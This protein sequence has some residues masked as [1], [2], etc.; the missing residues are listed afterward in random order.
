MQYVPNFPSRAPGPR[1]HLSF[2]NSRTDLVPVPDRFRKD[3]L[4]R[5]KSGAVGGPCQFFAERLSAQLLGCKQGLA[6]A[7]V[8]EKHCAVTARDCTTRVGEGWRLMGRA[9][10]EMAF[11]GRLGERGTIP[12]AADWGVAELMRAFVAI[13]S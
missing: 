13:E 2:G 6:K 4:L 5:N 10:L 12:W 7:T 9:Y 1:R 8:N 3:R 11:G